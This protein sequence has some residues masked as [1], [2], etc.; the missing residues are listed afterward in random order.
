MS[1]VIEPGKIFLVTN[2]DNYFNVF[3]QL[4]EIYPEIKKEQII[5]EPASLNTAPAIA[6]AVRYLVDKAGMNEDEPLISLP[7]DHFI[8]RPNDYAEVVKNA[9]LKVNGHIGTIG[10]TPTGPDTGFGYIKK[11]RK[12][13]DYWNVEVFKEK[14]NLE[15]AKEYLASGQ[16]VWNGGMYL[17][18]ARTFTIELEKHSSEL[19]A[20]FIKGY[21][22][23]LESFKDLKS[24][25]IDTAISEKSD[26]VV[27]FEG[28]FDWSDVGS[29]DVLSEI[30]AKNDRI[31]TKHEF[32]DSKN[33]YAHSESGKMIA[34]LGVDDIIVVE[35]N[36]VVFVQKRGRS[37][38]VKKVVG[39][40]K[41]KGAKEVNHNI[42]VYRPWGKYEVLIDNAANHK[43]KKIT[44]FPG[45]ALSLQSHEHRAEHWVVVKGTAK[46]VN[47]ENLLTLHENQSTY[48]PAK[49]KHQLSNPENEP[50]EIIEVQTG[51]Y[52]EEDDIVR[53]EDIYGRPS[54]I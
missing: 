3:N 8:G 35:S 1:K 47:G 23:F 6:L 15:T 13:D 4:K 49:C 25:A 17:F 26:N 34:T 22:E 32:V 42:V 11:G 40:L 41:E 54:G 53:Y 38:D 19:Y 44:V 10:I 30:A 9:L 31:S 33:V 2:Q 50:L 43:V 45:A 12:N 21:D 29:F 39:I 46:V 52:L 27:V 36:D 14:P 28:D 16:Y 51:D 24:E 48:I 37:E 20:K 18:T 7:S 5:V